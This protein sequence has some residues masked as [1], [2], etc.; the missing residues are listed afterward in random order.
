[1][2]GEEQGPITDNESARRLVK[3]ERAI[4]AHTDAHQKRDPLDRLTP[5]V[6]I[7]SL[8]GLEGIAIY[9]HEDGTMFMPIVAAIAALA[10]VKL[11]D[12]VRDIF[13]KKK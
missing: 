3:L 9:R 12:T 1:M 2:E 7:L 10:G 4:V 11:G 13:G 5:I 8:A 6:A